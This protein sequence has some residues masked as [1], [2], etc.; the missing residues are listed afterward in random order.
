MK[1][2]P[3]CVVGCGGMGNR[4][5][6]GMAALERTGLSNVELVAVC[7]LRQDYAERL[8]A[9]AERLVGR[10]PRIF[11]DVAEAAADP[12]VAAFDIC[13]EVSAHLPAVLPAL[14]ERKAVL[15]E[16][17]LS[18]TVRAPRKMI[19]AAEQS[20]TILATAENSRR[21]PPN[22]LAKAVIDAG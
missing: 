16:K 22:R 8:A 20:G 13:T 17:P 18:L 4:H 12:S 7:D 2:L 21:D 14:A 9:E 1:K 15:C 19:D 5:V 3:I 6:L 11:N 10:R